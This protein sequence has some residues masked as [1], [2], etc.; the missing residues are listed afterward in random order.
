MSGGAVEFWWVFLVGLAVVVAIVLVV[1]LLTREPPYEPPPGMAIATSVR[2]HK[3]ALPLLVRLSQARIDAQ[4][5]EESGK[6]LWR[7]LPLLLYS[8][9]PERKPSGPWYVLVSTADLSEAREVLS[10]SP[11]QVSVK[12]DGDPA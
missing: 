12:P 11:T 6:S 1:A 2:R 4:V 7:R 10:Q 3:D 8:L 9:Y 5:A